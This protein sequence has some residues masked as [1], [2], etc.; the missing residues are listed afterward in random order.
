V[1]LYLKGGREISL[2]KVYYASAFGNTCLLSVP[3][4]ALKGAELRF[5]SNKV[6]ILDSSCIVATGTLCKRLGLYRLNQLERHYIYRA[7]ITPSGKEITDWHRRFG[8]TNNDYI[9]ETAKCSK[10]LKITGGSPT[11]SYKPCLI[12]KATKASMK[13]ASKKET[14]L[15][16][17][18]IDYWGPSRIVLLNGNTVFFLI[19]D[20]SG[21]R[22]IEFSTER[23]DYLPKLKQWIALAERQT[24]KK[25]LKIRLDN[26][27]EYR[28][29]EMILWAKEMG[30]IL[31]FTTTYTHEQIGKNERSNRTILNT[32]R[33]ILYDSQL[34]EKYWEF[35]ASFW[36]YTSNRTW[37]KSLGHTPYEE[38]FEKQPD[39][40]ELRIFG[41]IC[42]VYNSTESSSQHKLLPRT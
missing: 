13:Q 35:A 3:Q 15:D 21:F 9:R 28:S 12:G 42:Y 4:L 33:S 25:V 19:S 38:W 1:T 26:A 11:G 29:Q 10:G 7:S 37:S 16:I 6:K 34:P 5:K 23:K 8:H 27:P 30:I 41:S 17:V 24:G 39:L 2:L 20:K 32:V 14:T 22:Y 40:S 31:Q 18:Y 36:V